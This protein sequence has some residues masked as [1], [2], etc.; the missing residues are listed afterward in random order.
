ME[1]VVVV[2]VVVVGGLLELASRRQL[3]THGEM[4]GT[5]MLRLEEFSEVVGRL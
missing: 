5:L 2:V 4:I 1:A 3:W